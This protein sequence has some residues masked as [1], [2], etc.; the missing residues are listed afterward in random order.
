MI[1][2]FIG[3]IF[4][5][6]KTNLSFW[7][8]GVTYYLTNIIGYLTM[9]FGI[10]ELGRT[11]QRL[12]KVKPYVIIMVIHSIIFLLLNITDHSP[13]TMGMSTMLETIIVFVGVVFIVIGMFMVFVIIFELMDASTSNI[14][15]KLLYNLVNIMLL[16]F[17]LAGLSAIFNFTM[18]VTTIM[19][20]LLLV[21][22]LFLISYYHVFLGENI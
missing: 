18:L 17:I 1:N 9:Y 20:T 11:N 6:F 16:L 7:D 12:L 14:N 3:L 5:F 4:V 10:Q 8:I 13:L 15:K 2:I 22:V 21:E 19:G